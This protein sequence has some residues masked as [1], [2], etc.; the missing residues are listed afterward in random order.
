MKTNGRERPEGPGTA[1]PPP[2]SDGI[3]HG[4]RYAI[5]NTPNS[6]LHLQSIGQSLVHLGDLGRDTEVD[7]AVAN[8]DDEAANQVGID[9]KSPSRQST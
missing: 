8:L 3:V 2:L 6:I 7:G 5:S 1:D 9:L 4:G